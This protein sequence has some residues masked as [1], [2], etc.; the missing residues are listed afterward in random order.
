MEW[1]QAQDRALLLLI[2]GAHSETEDLVMS[3]VSDKLM[4][5][6]LYVGLLVL[7]YY[8]VGWRKLLLLVV[9]MAAVIVVSDQVT[10]GILKPLVQRPRPCH[11]DGLKQFVHL[12]N[13]GKCGGAYGF[14]SSHAANFFALATYVGYFLRKRYRWFASSLYLI[15]ALV[16]YSRVYLGVHYPGDVL[17]G[18]AVGILAGLLGIFLFKNIAMRIP[19]PQTES[20]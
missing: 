20:K 10:S 17:A 16:A 7:L 4:W 19:F 2:N 15:A 12:G 5:I 13:E 8:V 14:A 9:I 6:P 11:L 1:L 3:L 18:M